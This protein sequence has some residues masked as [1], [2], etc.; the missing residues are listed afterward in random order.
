MAH[1]KKKKNNSDGW[2]AL[3]LDGAIVN[4]EIGGLIGIE[5]MTDYKL[6]DGKII[7]LNSSNS[8]KVI[9]R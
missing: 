4:S 8:K 6:Q 1:S 5:E 9:D 3:K 2:Q 7:S